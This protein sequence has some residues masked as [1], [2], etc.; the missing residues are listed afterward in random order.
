M[1]Q[2]WQSN[3]ELCF[4]DRAFGEGKQKK[5]YAAILEDRY[6]SIYI[7]YLPASLSVFPSIYLST[8]YQ[9]IYRSS[10]R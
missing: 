3:K 8:I 5:N 4:Q 1:D 7:I 6:L 9:H 2:V 10:H